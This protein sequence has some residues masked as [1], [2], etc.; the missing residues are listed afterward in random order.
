MT[1]KKYRFIFLVTHLLFI[2]VDKEIF[3]QE[4][5]EMKL[6]KFFIIFEKD[7]NSNL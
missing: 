1:S 7:G 2:F 5:T 3:F 6:K 4:Y